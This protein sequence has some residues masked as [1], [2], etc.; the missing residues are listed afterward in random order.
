MWQLRTER[1][2]WMCVYPATFGPL[3]RDA[4]RDATALVDLA[5]KL[6]TAGELDE[7]NLAHSDLA[8]ALYRLARTDYPLPQPVQSFLDANL[9]RPSLKAYIEHPRPPNRPQG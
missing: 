2:W 6:V 4:E 5:R 8:L 9:Q 1:P 3:S 7:W